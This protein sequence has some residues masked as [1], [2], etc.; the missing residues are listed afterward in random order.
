MNGDDARDGARMAGGRGRRRPVRS[1][2]RRRWLQLALAQAVAG[3]TGPGRAAAPERVDF[4]GSPFQLGI[5]S[6]QPGPTSVVLWTRLMPGNP[7]RNP[8]RDK[9]V[10]LEWQVAR[11]PDFGQIVQR[12]DTFAPPELS[13][14]V[15]VDVDGLEPNQ[16]YWYRF[17]G[18]GQTSP[19][20]RTRT[21]PAPDDASTP[22][23]LAVASCQRYH[24]GLFVAYDHMA[25]DAPD[26]VLF[27][28]DYIYEMGAST[29][30]ARGP[31]SWPAAKIADYRALYE[32]ARSDPSLQK[33]HAACPWLVIWDDHEV[34]ND[35]AG[36]PVR[37]QGDTGRLARRMEMAYRTWYEHMPVS[38]RALLG[39]MAGLLD[40]SQALQIHGTVRWGRVAN[41]HLLDTRQYRSPQVPCGTAGLFDPRDCSALQDAGRSMLGEAQAAW[42]DG[43]L[44]ANGAG[45]PDATHWNLICQSVVFSR[46][47]IPLFGGR[48][49]HDNWD[50]YPAA[51]RRILDAIA[52]ARTQGPVVLSGDIHQNWVAH[53][54]RD[55]DDP[56]TPVVAT[57]FCGTS[58]TT[59]SFGSFTAAEMQALAPH[60][61][62]ADR[63]RRG[64][65]LL[66]LTPQTLTVQLRHVDIRTG[67]A[68]PAP[69][70]EVP[71]SAPQIR[72][73]G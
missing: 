5:A 45:R 36:G 38:P 27:L 37:L 72:R 32:L 43:Q 6:G 26:L 73:L 16:V 10:H 7:M 19:V 4:E 67:A 62:Y 49:N 55:P 31:A 64:Y 54:H 9:T 52:E 14:S 53:L 59:A 20:G 50:G 46:F 11:D 65:S 70:F 2:A 15:H 48:L 3:V 39:G 56:A 1:P 60:C 33:M 30:E 23:R 51:R 44:R 63:H 58:I 35:Y 13:H 41:L 29:S 25:A 17:V 34:M 24:S 22:L 21:L 71:A 8:W 40:N 42:L 61:V 12:G 47:P 69:A 18:G 68:S 28:G 57:E 66:Q